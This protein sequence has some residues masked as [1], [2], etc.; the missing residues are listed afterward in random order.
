MDYFVLDACAF[1]RRYIPDVATRNVNAVFARPNKFIVIPTLA[2]TEIVSA[3]TAL[4]YYP[5][6]SL[7][8]ADMLLALNTF[9]ADYNLRSDLAAYPVDEVLASAA[10]DC[11]ER[12]SAIP[13]HPKLH[14]AD[15]IYLALALHLAGPPRHPSAHPG[16]DR[17]I[18]VSQDHQVLVAAQTEAA[19][20]RV[21][22]FLVFN[23]RT[24]DTGHG[25][26]ND[27]PRPGGRVH[28]PACAGF[29][30]PCEFRTCPSTYALNF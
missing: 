27:D 9:R 5:P 4:H 7:P 17:V 13:G 10:A 28:C 29:C 3:I 26:V 23:S 15:A 6:Q 1:V 8:R 25:H 20:L 2:I 19:T 30:E 22:G 16:P 14:G 24:C 11:L 21:N 12:L 18:L